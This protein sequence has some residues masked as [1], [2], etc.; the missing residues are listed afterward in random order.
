MANE[1]QSSD[2]VLMVRPAAFGFN[3]ETAATNVF[4]AAV[5]D[6]CA[7]AALAEFDRAAERLASAG[8]EVVVLED[9]PD[10][11]RPDAAFPN[12]WVSFHGD[13]TLV[14]YPMAAPTRRLE[15]RS[16]RFAGAAGGSRL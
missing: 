7:A 5:A 2:A 1:R 11:A 16:R 13:G 12:N 3:P 9:S 6:E 8:V 15:R 4:A 10:P 14:L